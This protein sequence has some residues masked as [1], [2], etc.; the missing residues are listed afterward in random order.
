MSDVWT[1]IVFGGF[2]TYATR[3]AGHVL[4]GRLETIPPRLEAALNAVP[5]AVITTIVTPALVAGDWAERGA[6]LLC[7][8]LSFRLPLIVTVAIG[9][10]VVALARAYG[11]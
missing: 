11:A 7:F 1:L 9:T 6:I 8:C 4:I 5:A 10:A 2:L 3:F